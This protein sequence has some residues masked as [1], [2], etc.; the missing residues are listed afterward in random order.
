MLSM[1]DQYGALT[2]DPGVREE[3]FLPVAG[4]TVFRLACLFR[5]IRYQ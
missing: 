3:S 1:L 2:M 5:R 4:M